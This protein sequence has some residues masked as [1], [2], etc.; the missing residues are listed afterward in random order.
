MQASQGRGHVLPAHRGLDDR[1]GG[2]GLGQVDPRSRHHPRHPGQLGGGPGGDHPHPGPEA[3]RAQSRQPR[4]RPVHGLLVRQ[5][6]GRLLHLLP[7]VHPGAPRDGLLKRDALGGPAP[8]WGQSALPPRQR[9]CDGGAV[10]AGHLSPRGLSHAALGHPPGARPVRRA[11][12]PPPRLPLLQ[13][14]TPP[15][16]RRRDRR[17][18]RRR[19]PRRPLPLLL[20]SPRGSARCVVWRPATSWRSA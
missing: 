17:P 20:P 10:R 13:S 14:Q 7:Q 1:R 5:R 11:S 15:R 2:G 12:A 16:N 8:R 6:Q 4:R 9:L 19:N 3:L 18:P